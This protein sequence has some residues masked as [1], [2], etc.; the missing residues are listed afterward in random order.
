MRWDLDYSGNIVSI[1]CCG[2]TWL[3]GGEEI[4][5]TLQH[6]GYMYLYIWI[7]TRFEHEV[8]C[9]SPSILYSPYSLTNISLACHLFFFIPPFPIQS[10][11]AGFPSVGD[12][13]ILILILL[14]SHESPSSFDIYRATQTSDREIFYWNKHPACIHLSSSASVWQ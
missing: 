11:E 10:P 1:L 13:F 2:A 5:A 14:H 6:A 12:S 9:I 8:V 3:G 7:G 4:H